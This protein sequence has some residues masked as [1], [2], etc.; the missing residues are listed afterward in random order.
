MFTKEEIEEIIKGKIELDEKLGEQAGGSGHLSYVTYQINDFSFKEQPPD[1]IEISYKYSLYVETEF[2]YY[3]DNPPYESTYSKI[4]VI[5]QNKN[6]I[7][8]KADYNTEKIGSED[9]YSDKDWEAV[10]K[11]ILEYIEQFLARIEWRYGEGRAPIKYPPEFYE[12]LSEDIKIEYHCTI[13]LDFC[14]DEKLYYSSTNP[15][16][17]P[18]K[19]KEDFTS[20]FPSEA[21]IE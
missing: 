15:Y 21:A 16:D 18:G 13:E 4:I 10:Q 12:L 3:P 1:K 8:E 19:I 11:D 17:L 14:E 5:D 2:T 9:F 6:I 20:R 7:E